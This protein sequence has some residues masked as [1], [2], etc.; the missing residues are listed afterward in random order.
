[1]RRQVAKT[2]D[3]TN[4]VCL[5]WLVSHWPSTWLNTQQ[6]N[7]SEE[8]VR[9]DSS[10][11]FYSQARIW[12]SCPE[13][14]ASTICTIVFFVEI[15]WPCVQEGIRHHIMAGQGWDLRI[16]HSG[17][18][19]AAVR[20]DSICKREGMD[21]VLKPRLHVREGTIPYHTLSPYHTIPYVRGHGGSS[22][23]PAL[24]LPPI[25]RILSKVV[26][27]TER[28]FWVSFQLGKGSETRVTE[29]FCENGWGPFNSQ[30]ALLDIRGWDPI[31]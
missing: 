31:H 17:T 18:R 23:L 14:L 13:T 6:W 12:P 28:A 19:A 16:L 11:L 10:L 30:N 29:S 1:M 7:V 25:I 24:P 8:T 3:L 9:Q 15:L 4:L 26:R 27:N 2:A 20:A 5:I 22:L 21:G